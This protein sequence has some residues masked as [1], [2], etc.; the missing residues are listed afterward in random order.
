[1][2]NIGN[3]EG[4]NLIIAAI[5]KKKLNVI[6]ILVKFD[7]N[8]DYK[9]YS[10]LLAI[11][12][13]YKKYKTE[14]MTDR[15]VSEDIILALLNANSTYSVI[16]NDNLR[17]TYNEL[18]QKV[19]DFTAQNELLH[20]QLINHEWDS[21][22]NA[23]KTRPNL[24]HFYDKYNRSLMSQA[25]ETYDREAYEHL[26]SY[27]IST[28][29]HENLDDV[30]QKFKDKQPD[31]VRTTN[32][33][34]SIELPEA[35]IYSIISKIRVINNFGRRIF[36]WT[37]IIMDA[38]KLLDKNDKC[39]KILKV[40]ALCKNL[41]IFLDLK[42]DSINHF[43]PRFPNNQH[44][45]TQIIPIDEATV[46]EIITIGAKKLMDD[47]K[48]NDVIGVLI[49]ELCHLAIYKTFMNNYNPYSVNDENKKR[50]FEAIVQE[51]KNNSIT[52]DIVRNVFR[53]YAESKYHLELIVAVVHTLMKY[54]GIEIEKSS[55]SPELQ[56][57]L[58]EIDGVS[59]VTVNKLLPIAY[60]SLFDY[61]ENTVV[62]ELENVLKPLKIL[63]DK[64][65]EIEFK[66]LTEPMKAKLLHQQIDFQGAITTL[67]EVIGNDENIYQHLTSE[68]IRY[69]LNR[70]TVFFDGTKV[71][72]P[73][74]IIERRFLKILNNLPEPSNTNNPIPLDIISN[75]LKHGGVI[76][77]A[78]SP[79]S[80]KTS[81]FIDIAQKLKKINKNYLVLLLVL[82]NNHSVNLNDDDDLRMDQIETILLNILN[83]KSPIEKQIFKKL[84]RENKIIF[85]FDGL[86]KLCPEVRKVFLKIVNGLKNK[87]YQNSTIQQWVSTRLT[88][89]IRNDHLFQ[90]TFNNIFK[91]APYTDD[92]RADYVHNTI[93]GGNREKLEGMVLHFWF[94]C[95]IK[96]DQNNSQQD[97]L[98]N[99]FMELNKEWK[100]NQSSESLNFYETILNL[101]I[102]QKNKCK[103]S[104][105]AE[106]L[107]PV[108]ISFESVMHVNALYS[109]FGE[110]SK[111]FAELKNWD[112][113]GRTIWTQC[114]IEPFGF[115]NFNENSETYYRKFL[116]EAYIEFFVS[117]FLLNILYAEWETI[118]PKQ[119]NTVVNILIKMCKSIESHD[120][121][122]KVILGYIKTTSI[123]SLN[124]EVKNEITQK[125]TLLRSS[126][127]ESNHP[128]EALKFW[129]VILSIDLNILLLLWQPDD[130]NGLLRSIVSNMA[131][132]PVNLIKIFEVGSFSF[133]RKLHQILDQRNIDLNGNQPSVNGT[134][135]GNFLNIFD[136]NI[137]SNEILDFFNNYRPNDTFVTDLKK[138]IS[139]VCIQKCQDISKSNENIFNEKCFKF[140]DCTDDAKLQKYFCENFDDRKNILSW[141]AY[142]GMKYFEN[143]IFGMEVF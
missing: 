101:Y 96:C 89:S 32:E 124:D 18:P 137:N 107:D 110:D 85:L 143:D 24:C 52:E 123:L 95:T 16:R 92:E 3:K 67:F 61:F 28:G 70:G 57:E 138:K 122:H 36:K 49:H 87:T 25:L 88:T 93:N 64:S 59:T 9:D 14:F 26:V 11:D 83:P 104:N 117:H 50:E 129:S 119:A 79:F 98:I 91:F 86:D 43:D 102:Q 69:L 21:L 80:G 51:Y 113:K 132:C 31:E 76:L 106:S 62:P 63:E 99:S 111:Q 58:M 17:L 68:N 66:D 23:F 56:G 35:H 60:K 5:I 127:I 141:K 40:V 121:I 94:L 114:K 39:S 115:L 142:F 27:G 139:D 77:L 22:K 120:I 131:T 13:A 109:K 81:A 53:S 6:E 103:K 48:K 75:D 34:Y 71:A 112:R 33:K 78:D 4:H 134:C 100:V 82:D 125:I 140:I 2:R 15:T 108:Q 37:K 90:N 8:I 20:G 84:F 74:E 47:A 38:L 45:V 44:G 55:I 54:Y 135:E 72:K 42:N 116:N 65:A 10:H 126:I 97:S 118:S 1:M 7:F 73:H 12:H 133:G 136:N 105:E 128:I 41:K 130:T 30:F 19:K 46:T 29:S